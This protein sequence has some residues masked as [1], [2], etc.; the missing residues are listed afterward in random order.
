MTLI[1]ACRISGAI[2]LASA[3]FWAFT[4]IG[5]WAPIQE[6]DGGRLVI[7]ILIHFLAV[8]AAAVSLLP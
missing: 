7:L 6:G 5:F 1:R 2:A 8:I 4:G 3:I